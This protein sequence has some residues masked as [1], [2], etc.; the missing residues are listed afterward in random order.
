MA[1]PQLLQAAPS[2]P[3]RDPLSLVTVGDTAQHVKKVLGTNYRICAADS[4]DV[5]KD[6]VWLYQVARGKPL[7]VAVRFHN[8]RV[9]AVF[10]LGVVAGWR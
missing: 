8:G 7:G 4:Y 9:I 5:C 2:A 3:A 6:P 10:R 1:C